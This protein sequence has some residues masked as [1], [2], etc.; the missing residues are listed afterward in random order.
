MSIFRDI[1]FQNPLRKQQFYNKLYQKGKSRLLF[2]PKNLTFWNEYFGQ[3]NSPVS[4]VDKYT[5]NEC[6]FRKKEEN[7]KISMQL[8]EKLETVAE[9]RLE[10]SEL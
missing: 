10:K 7:Q 5:K 8:I 4:F 3:Y 9:M 2:E 6:L 1:D